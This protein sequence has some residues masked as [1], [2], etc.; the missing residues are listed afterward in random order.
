VHNSLLRPFVA[1]G[2]FAR[3]ELGFTAALL[4]LGG[5]LAA[6]IDISE[7]LGEDPKHAFDMNVLMALRVPGH[8][9]DPIGPRWLEIVATDITALGSTAVLTLLAL[10]VGGFLLMK[11]KPWAVVTLT[12]ALLGGLA[13]SQT[14]KMLF[15]RE[16]PPPPFRLAEAINASFPSGHAMLSA[17]AFLTLGALLAKV[18]PEKRS[19]AYVMGAAIFVAMLVGLTR[20]YLGVHWATDVFAG[21]AVGAVW[22]MLCWIAAWLIERVHGKAG[23]SVPHPSRREKAEAAIGPG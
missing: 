8:P 2:R 10:L 19:K 14:L 4:V 11:R 5:G 3:S 16:R 17:I 13:L 22:A 15:G 6:F 20:I 1:A 12:T 7:D 21:W 18:L 23:I 9:H